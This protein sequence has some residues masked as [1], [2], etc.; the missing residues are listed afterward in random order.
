MKAIAT[1]KGQIVV[2]KAVT[3]SEDEVNKMLGEQSEKH[4]GQMRDQAF[5]HRLEHVDSTVSSVKELICT[6]MEEGKEEKKN[7]LIAIENVGAERRHCEE[8]VNG[9][10]KDMHEY[11]HKTFVKKTDL[12]VYSLLIVAAVTG[13]TGF[14]TW[15]GLQSSANETSVSADKIAKTIIKELGK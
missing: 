5:N 2:D 11:N 1:N 14:I 13:T 8:R 3:F 15:L 9:E 6:H 7:I 4:E 12:R 10:I